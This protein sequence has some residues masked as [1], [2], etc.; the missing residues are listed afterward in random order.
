MKHTE[1]EYVK[2][3]GHTN[4]IEGFFSIFKRGMTGVYQ[5]CSEKHLQR[6]L[7]E[8]D[9]RYNHRIGL[10]IDDTMRADTAIKGVAHKRLTYRRT[11]GA[12]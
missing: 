2:D 9:F 10:E 4:A 8:F 11:N 1:N 7:N 3:G 6:Y 12:A 5:H